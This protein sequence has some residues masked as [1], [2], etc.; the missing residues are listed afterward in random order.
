MLTHFIQ[1]DFLPPDLLEKLRELVRSNRDRFRAT[2]DSSRGNYQNSLVL[3]DYPIGGNPE[4]DEELRQYIADQVKIAQETLEFWWRFEKQEIDLHIA[5]A[6]DDYCYSPRVD[7]HP[8]V[9][10][11]LSRLI[12]FI[13]CFSMTDEQQFSGGEVRLRDEEKLIELKHNQMVWF[14]TRTYYELLPVSVPERE[15]MHH[16]FTCHGAVSMPRLMLPWVKNFVDQM[17]KSL[18]GIPEPP[19]PIWA[20]IG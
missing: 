7:V 10:P 14:N 12:T 15:F 5:S 11:T 6:G 1:D 4:F 13:Y 2:F 9:F 16:R 19:E 8:E 18:L 20:E 17:D 3:G